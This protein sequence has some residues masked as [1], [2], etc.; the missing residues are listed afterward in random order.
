[1]NAPDPVAAALS[2]VV[3]V[4][5]VDYLRENQAWGWMRLVQGSAVLRDVPGL[6]FSK[7]MG[8]G[9]DGG[10]TLRPSTTHQGLICLFDRADQADAFLTGSHVQQMRERARESWTGLL[11][12]TAA[13][14]SWDGE[15]WA[16]T[17][18]E[19]LGPYSG[20]ALAPNPALAAL[21][22]A[23]IRPAKAATFWRM[24]PAAQASL[25]SAPGCELAAGLGEAPLL[26]QCTF[27]LWRDVSSMDAYAQHGAHQ[28]AIASAYKHSFF[29]ESMFVR[30][31]LLAGSG[32]WKGR[33]PLADDAACEVHAAGDAH[34]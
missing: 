23:S 9:H 17:H 21:T 14:G 12:I 6:R 33:H 11:S 5:L 16:P 2:G 1:M 18:S 8:S 34:G 32:V 10:F 7:V 30:L 28:Q 3:V 22:R 27:S 13:R 25:W 4:I 24:A 20:A 31:R 26:R 29:S 19:S 15:A